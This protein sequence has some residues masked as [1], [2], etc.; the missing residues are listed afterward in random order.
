[1]DEEASKFDLRISWTKTKLQDLGSGLT[2]SPTIVDGNSVD[3]VEDFT[4]LGSIQSSSSNSG[5][6]YIRRIGL[7]AS[8]TKRLDC[9]WS[10]SKLSRPIATKLRM[11]ST[12]V[13]STLRL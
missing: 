7:A 13:L 9:I 10:Q 11:Y 6:E 8:A 4:Y 2:P 12:Y 1:M 5:P 3:S